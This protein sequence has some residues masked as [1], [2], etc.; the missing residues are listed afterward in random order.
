[1]TVY[2]ESPIPKIDV[3]SVEL[4]TKKELTSKMLLDENLVNS[5]CI[6]LQT[7][8]TID[9]IHVKQKY[10]SI[11][12]IEI[13]KLLFMYKKRNIENHDTI[14]SLGIENNDCIKVFF[15]N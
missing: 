1:M 9:L 8:P 10:S 4:S 7:K 14:K 15:L 5:E 2:Q 11:I 12:G 13:H 3:K 6:M